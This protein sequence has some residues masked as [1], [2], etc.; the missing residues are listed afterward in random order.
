MSDS[1]QPKTY[2]DDL[3]NDVIICAGGTGA[4]AD[5][6]TITLPNDIVN[7]NTMIGNSY[8]S[9]GSISDTITLPGDT[10]NISWG[11]TEWVD[12]FPDFDRVK[13]MCLKYPGLE[14]ALRNFE[15]IYKLVK[16]DYDNPTPKN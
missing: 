15:T 14:I 7:Y 8:T 4:S 3:L 5:S 16:D 2:V 1:S 13:D 10:F 11:T 9:I 6:I 12:T